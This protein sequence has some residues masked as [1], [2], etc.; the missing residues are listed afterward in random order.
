MNFLGFVIIFLLNES[1][2]CLVIWGYMYYSFDVYF[3]SFYFLIFFLVELLGWI[4]MGLER[5]LLDFYYLG[6]LMEYFFIIKGDDLSVYILE[7]FY[8]LVILYR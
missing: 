8:I 4:K 5:Y 1:E 6:N 7:W 2:F 3:K